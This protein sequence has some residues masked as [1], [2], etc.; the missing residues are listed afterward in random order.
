[1]PPESQTTNPNHWLQHQ[2]PEKK[3]KNN[4]P[5]KLPRFVLLKKNQGT[6][7]LQ[8]HEISQRMTLLAHIQIISPNSIILLVTKFHQ[9]DKTSKNLDQG[10][11]ETCETYGLIALDKALFP[12]GRGGFFFGGGD[13]GWFWPWSKTL[14]VS[15][16]QQWH[17]PQMTTQKHMKYTPKF[18]HIPVQGGLE[19]D[20]SLLSCWDISQFLGGYTPEI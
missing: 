12:P 16:P 3:K 15:Q 10:R 5:K 11:G 6:V 7:I 20:V 18:S 17:K 4:R 1:M 14:Q 9:H 13:V 2:T 8:P 19:N